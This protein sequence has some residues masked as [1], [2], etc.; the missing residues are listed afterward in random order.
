MEGTM[1]VEAAWSHL[2]SPDHWLHLNGRELI[3]KVF[4][5]GVLTTYLLSNCF[6]A[7]T[8]PPPTISVNDPLT[9]YNGTV[10]TLTGV[11][12]LDQSVNTDITVSGMWSTGN[13]P[14][15]TTSPPYPTSLSFQP[16]T[17][18]SSG[19]YL[20]TVT[21]RPS[22]NSPFIVG[23]SGSTTYN[24]VVQRKLFML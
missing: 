3:F 23:S 17:S 11:V 22:D 2:L 12:Q 20:L 18:D 9:P 5:Y 6:L 16:L 21:I 7:C 4:N 19:E 14:Q 24:L 8:V 15:E 13:G 1:T 10:F